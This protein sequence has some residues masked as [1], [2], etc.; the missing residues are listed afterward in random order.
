MN[1]FC[2]RKIYIKLF[3]LSLLSKK[4]NEDLMVLEDKL[5]AQEIAAVYID[6]SIRNLHQS[7]TGNDSAKSRW[8]GLF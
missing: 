5:E 3:Q 4:F 7:K 2:N 1:V 8:A 6:T